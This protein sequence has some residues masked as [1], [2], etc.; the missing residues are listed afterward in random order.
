MQI[1]IV[2]PRQL[3]DGFDSDT[4]SSGNTRTVLSLSMQSATLRE[5]DGHPLSNETERV[6]TLA[7]KID[8]AKSAFVCQGIELPCHDL[9]ETVSAQEI[10]DY[11]DQFAEDKWLKTSAINPIISSF[12][13]PVVTRVLHS[14]VLEVDDS[15]RRTQHMQRFPWALEP[16]HK[17]VIVPSYHDHH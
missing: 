16:F 9:I 15:D 17:N 6:E 14:R 11:F 7:Q 5:S 10:N 8:E 3:D 12:N 4:E 13:W 1:C 2:G